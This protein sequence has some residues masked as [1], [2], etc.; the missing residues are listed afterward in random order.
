MAITLHYRFLL[1]ALAMVSQTNQH[2]LSPFLLYAALPPPNKRKAHA[3]YAY[4]FMRK[5]LFGKTEKYGTKL[6]HDIATST[7]GIHNNKA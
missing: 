1:M 3:T 4:V 2:G 7:P 5:Y 6:C